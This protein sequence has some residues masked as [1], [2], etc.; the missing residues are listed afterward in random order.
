[1]LRSACCRQPVEIAANGAADTEQPAQT[2][3]DDAPATATPSQ[4]DVC[5]ARATAQ[6]PRKGCLN[7]LD[8]AFGLPAINLFGS[9]AF[10]PCRYLGGAYV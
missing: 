9:K 5:I 7:F 4:A 3:R 10:E 6:T 2:L 1:M 8:S